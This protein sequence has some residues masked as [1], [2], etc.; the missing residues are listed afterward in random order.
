MY[1]IFYF[2]ASNSSSPYPLSA[3]SLDFV[4]DAF[5][6]RYSYIIG[7]MINDPFKLIAQ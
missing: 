2:P 3:K 1:A 7:G 4:V 5:N 6:F